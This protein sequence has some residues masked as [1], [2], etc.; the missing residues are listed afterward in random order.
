VKPLFSAIRQNRQNTPDRPQRADVHVDAAPRTM[1]GMTHDTAHTIGQADDDAAARL[2]RT[3]ATDD[4]LR[5]VLGID[6]TRP[7]VDVNGRRIDADTTDDIYA[8]V[9]AAHPPA[10]DDAA[11]D[12]VDTPPAAGADV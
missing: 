11:D 2:L 12:D 10:D 1:R 3:A 4:V 6:G 8:V 9:L 7:V 5:A